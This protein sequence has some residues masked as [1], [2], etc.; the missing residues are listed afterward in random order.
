[1]TTGSTV[2]L[3]AVGLFWAAILLARAAYMAGVRDTREV[4][5]D[6]EEA[7]PDGM[8][9]SDGGGASGGE[10]CSPVLNRGGDDAGQDGAQSAAGSG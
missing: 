5:R 8:L 9:G 3:V 7:E 2:V 10:H 6:H 1:M 4:W